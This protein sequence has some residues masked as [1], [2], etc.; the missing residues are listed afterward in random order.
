MNQ[1]L[2]QEQLNRIIA[3]LGRLKE[4]RE[5]EL[6]PEQ[7]KQILDELNLP[8][9]LL[10]EAM[11]QVARSQ[12]LEASQRRNKLILGSV[13]AA[14]VVIIGSGILFSQQRSDTLARVT[15]QS[16][17]VDRNN[18]EL[19]YRVTLKEAPVGQKLN[20]SCNWINP[21]GQI[22]KQNSYE[23]KSITT[24]VW[25]T[26]CKYTLNSGAETGKWKVQM[27]LDGR[28]LEEESFEVK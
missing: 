19:F 28:T 13:A 26:H 24:S 14:L 22:V 7:V 10:G 11:T 25:D 16:D 4:R 6:E 23:T 20:L 9:D 18:S 15:A 12:L 27:L 21:S 5:Q 3:E 1:R 8:P 17:R 2:T